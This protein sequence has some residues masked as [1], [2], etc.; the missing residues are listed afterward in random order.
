[1][2]E[3][4][5]KTWI[6]WLHAS[7][8]ARFNSS[9]RDVV[10]QLQV[11]GGD[12]PEADV[13]QLLRTW[14]RGGEERKWLVIID[15]AD[16]KSVLLESPTGKQAESQGQGQ[17]TW[18]S[19]RCIDYLPA[20]SHGSLLLTTRSQSVALDVVEHSDVVMVEP[21]ARDHAIALLAKKLGNEHNPE[22]V[23]QLA[24]ELDFVPLAMVQAAAYIRRMD[25]RCS[26]AQY[27]AKLRKSNRS[28]L[29]EL[30]RDEG[31]LRRDPGAKNSILYTWQIS[32]E[33]ILTMRRSAADL[34]SLMSCFDRQA[35]PE[36]LLRG[37]DTELGDQTNR[38][39]SNSHNTDEQSNASD[40]DH[41]SDDNSSLMT[42]RE[43]FEEDLMVLRGYSF[44]SVN[45]DEAT[46]KMHRLVQLITQEWLKS[47]GS[48]EH[49]RSQF[50][51]NLDRA[52]PVGKFE[53]WEKCRELFP[54]ATLALDVTLSDRSALLRQASLL[55]NGGWYA[56]EQG[57]YEL[58]KRMRSQSMELRNRELGS[59]HP[60]TVASKGN[61]ALV[62][63]NQGQY[64]QAAELGEQVFEIRKRVLGLGDLQTAT[65]MNNLASTYQ[66]LRQLPKA[67]KLQKQALEIRERVLGPQHLDTV[68]SMNNLVSI[69]QYQGL[70]DLAAELGTQALRIRES[71]LGSENPHTTL[72]MTNLAITL[73]Y[74]GRYA[75]AAEL[76][77]RAL[78]IRKRLFRPDH[79]RITTSMSNLAVTYRHLGQ[80]DQ[81]ARLH[82]EVLEIRKRTLGARHPDT[83]ISMSNLAS[84]YRHQGLYDKAAD[85]GEQVLAARRQ[86]LE[87][88]HLDVVVSMGNL[89]STYWHQKLYHRAVELGRH[90]LEIRTRVLGLNHPHTATSMR[91]LALCYY[92]QGLFK[93]AAE[94]QRQAL[95]IRQRVLG[96]KHPETLSIVDELAR[97][98]RNL[99]CGEGVTEQ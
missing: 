78:T 48:L 28:I 93:E 27:V 61:L 98:L 82:A 43:E 87:P 90:V 49:W 52:F 45:T 16:D 67:A 4:S 64:K 73:Q 21:M 44:V 34:L 60:D 76:G 75:Q 36:A 97:T 95:G 74:Q 88:D 40:D 39:I 18:Q 35:I 51:T 94:L 70:Y 33:H 50:I 30:K 46:F 91:S 99:D 86:I 84:M 80:L 42:G 1:V 26:V 7:S 85:L 68:N 6:L 62:Y 24:T 81:A 8:A 12:D 9:V 38:K 11:P 23:A 31:N 2:K 77:E 53:N 79:P 3:R 56:M 41:S 54:H 63:L 32:F 55:D 25:P 29:K 47:R 37:K 71:V 13:F 17:Q 72:S 10:A 66:H 14:L 20:C 57:N 58:S 59:E 92:S 15:S 19:E 65:S 89:A 5:P 83:V 22:E 69:Y 96:P